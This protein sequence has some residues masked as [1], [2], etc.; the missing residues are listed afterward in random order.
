M[1][2]LLQ[3]FSVRLLTQGRRRVCLVSIMLAVFPS[4]F[5]LPQSALRLIDSWG[6]ILK[7]R[8]WKSGKSKFLC[9]RPCKRIL[10]WFEAANILARFG[11]YSS[12]PHPWGQGSMDMTW[13]LACNDG[14]NLP[15]SWLC[16]VQVK[17]LGWGEKWSCPR[18]VLLEKDH[19]VGPRALSYL[20]RLIWDAKEQS[21][22][23]KHPGFYRNWW[24]QPLLHTRQQV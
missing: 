17:V 5:L 19:Q 10:R 3:T 20:Q 6:N 14:L 1:L 2:R 18:A 22:V 13:P 8:H 21:W 9:R 4:A 11:E 16:P 23:L 15:P 24:S 12:S 7:I